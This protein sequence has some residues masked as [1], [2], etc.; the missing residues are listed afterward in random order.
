MNDTQKQIEALETQKA[1]LM[2]TLPYTIATRREQIKIKIHA[3]DLHID[4]L[5]IAFAKGDTQ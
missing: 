3:I 1:N 4:K 2:R 5:V